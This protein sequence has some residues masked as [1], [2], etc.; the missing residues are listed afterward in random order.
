MKEKYRYLIK[1]H[2]QIVLSIMCRFASYR[3]DCTRCQGDDE[4]QPARDAV[5]PSRCWLPRRSGSLDLSH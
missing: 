5:R 4:Q 2:F 1:C 3:C